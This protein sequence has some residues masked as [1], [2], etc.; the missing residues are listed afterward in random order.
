MEYL[1]TKNQLKKIGG[2]QITTPSQKSEKLQSP[3]SL[4]NLNCRVQRE[5]KPKL[6]FYKRVCARRT[7]FD[8]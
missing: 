3:C 8:R 6:I 7:L 4:N 5:L 1:A 2:Y